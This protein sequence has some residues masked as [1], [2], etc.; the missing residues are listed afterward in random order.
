MSSS[1][2]IES[3]PVAEAAADQ[4]VE[5]TAT[6][7]PNSA[8]TG[9][10]SSLKT[11]GGNSVV[12]FMAEGGVR[13]ATLVVTPLYTHAMKPRDYGILA[14]AA[15]TS[16]VVTL[17]L[18][19]QLDNAISRLTVEVKTDEERRRL[20]GTILMFLL[21]ASLLIALVLEVL[22]GRGYLHLFR[23]VP[24]VPYLRYAVWSGYLAIFPF[25]PIALYTLRGEPRKVLAI[26][27][28]TIIVQVSVGVTLI[29]FLHQGAIGALRGILA[30][31][32]VS[33]VVSII[34]MVRHAAFRFSRRLLMASFAFCLP[35]IPHS[36]AN[37]VLSL[38]DRVV[39]QHYVND[40]Q[41]G[42]YQLGYL[43]GGAATLFTNAASGALAP[44][45]YWRLRSDEARG[46]VP[47]LG[48]YVLLG[49]SFLCVA[50]AIFGGTAIRI[51]TP[52]SY[53]GATVIVPW[54]AASYIFVSVY[55]L[56]T[57]ATWYV[58]RTM[59]LAL[60][61]IAAGVINVGTTFLFGSLFG[62]V[63]AG[64]STLIGYA[65]L[66]LIQGLI[67]KQL[68]PIPWEYRR[69]FKIMCISG[70]CLGL[71]LLIG[72]AP[73]A[74]SILLRVVVLLAGF[75]VSL[76]LVR[77]WTDAERAEIRGLLVAGRKAAARRISAVRP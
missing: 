40:T 54:V 53:H 8:I 37:W 36:I 4:A 42:L 48:S 58:M 57:F 38:S 59:Q 19:L 13:A 15:T 60:G 21:S 5:Q 23:S 69:W 24:Y 7:M 47:P 28:L 22:G 71:G 39:L 1:K 35:I 52:P 56:L 61:T 18:S 9:L 65:S 63:G 62:I 72:D 34:L 41:L 73:T 30:G 12:Y 11:I 66:A 6:P 46:Q 16:M 68:Y 43:V 31:A 50:L 27:Y 49:L 32:A 51:V 76:Y 77:F 75:P 55:I 20:V 29:V 45:F 2:Q 70:V 10:R 17:V 3:P 26:R 44:L 64:I 14:V 25:L 67:A 33:A 74:Q